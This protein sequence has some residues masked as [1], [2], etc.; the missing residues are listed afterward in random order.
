MSTENYYKEK[1]YKIGGYRKTAILNFIDKTNP[2]VLDIGCGDGE[3]GEIIKKQKGGV[4]H[5]IDISEASV[6]ESSIKLDKTF[7]VDIE[8]KEAWP[9]ELLEN[10][11]DYIVISEVFE[12]L[13]D[14][15][16]VL[17]M[18]K[19]VSN[20]DTKIIITVPNLLFW[21]NRLQIFL[22]NFNYTA[23][24]LMDRGHIHI[25]SW[26]SFKEMISNNG[27]VIVSEKNNI[28]T[29]GTKFLGKIFPGLFSYQ[30]VV[31]VKLTD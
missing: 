5:G 22:G 1:V 27:L 17:E 29:R 7:C 23:T 8:K 6:R 31:S 25:F 12:H 11:Y 14:Q 21:K 2:K 20:K 10:T 26:K 16:V 30:F 13:F 28:P 9:A 4:V 3:L 19:K 24:G 15:D 18:L